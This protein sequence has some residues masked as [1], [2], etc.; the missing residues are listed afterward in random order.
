ML[1]GV[2][3]AVA[4]LLVWSGWDYVRYRAIGVYEVDLP[5]VA[6]FADSY[7]FALGETVD[8]YVHAKDAV[9]GNLFRLGESRELVLSQFPVPAQPQSNTFALRRGLDWTRTTELPTDGLEP[10]FYSL[11]L[12]IGGMDAEHPYIVP[13]ILKGQA[14]E[15]AVVLSTNTWDAYNAFGGVS[16][17]VNDHFGFLTR[18]IIDEVEFWG[19]R[20]PDIPL[21]YSRPNDA[22]SLDLAGQTDPTTHYSSRLARHEW[23]FIAFLEANGYA[24][25]LI[26][27]RDLAFETDWMEAAVLVFPGHSEYWSSEMFF[28]FERYVH[29]GGRVLMTAGNPMLK[30]VTFR[31]GFLDF[32]QAT[33]AEEDINERIGAAFNRRGIFTSAPFEVL[34]PDHWV[35][36]GTGLA[37]GDLFGM[38]STT[39]PVG[40]SANA[41]NRVGQ[42]A[43]GFFTLK[44]GQ[45]SGG[46]DV[47][48]VGLNEDGGAHMMFRETS[49]GGWIFNSS[50]GTF[51]GALMED[52]VIRTIVTNLLDDALSH[53][54]VSNAP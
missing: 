47:L 7:S 34:V 32:H 28:A 52:E 45:G 29:A 20:F 9:V 3:I 10:G 15:I 31:D 51:T 49:S 24:Y 46:F 4:A 40:D 17:Y 1:L 2:M 12:S 5:P 44:P 13:I 25:S 23:T 35:F 50:S 54:P 27:D 48:A 19:G 21:P 26:T 42:G 11:E 36:D 37:M 14:A 18:R 39:R 41:A 30:R 53:Q 16:N 38:A 43:S 8:L 22:I 6:A 33:V